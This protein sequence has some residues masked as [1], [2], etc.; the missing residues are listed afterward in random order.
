ME[1]VEA[2]LAHAPDFLQDLALYVQQRG[3]C[4]GG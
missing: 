1:Q 2:V 3:R 4:P